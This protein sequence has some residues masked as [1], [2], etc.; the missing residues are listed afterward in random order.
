[1]KNQSIQTEVD[2]SFLYKKL[3]EYE[4]DETIA[5]VFRQMSIIERSHAEAFAKKE[6]LS[7]EN[8][9]L[10]SWRAKTLNTIGKVFGYDYV[11]GTLMA[12]EKSIANAIITA[13]QKNIP[14][15]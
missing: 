14:D 4:A 8:L 13:K 6:N 11:L 7:V 12:T 2:T 5:N 9:M 10:P 3:A 15:N 1:M